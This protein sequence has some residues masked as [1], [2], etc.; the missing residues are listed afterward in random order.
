MYIAPSSD[1]ILLNINMPL[2]DSKEVF[3]SS[4]VWSENAALFERMME[5]HSN[6]PIL[7]Y[8]FKEEK[9]REKTIYYN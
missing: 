8:G 9:E 6:P 3:F 4:D 7:Y 5:I 1:H 2:I